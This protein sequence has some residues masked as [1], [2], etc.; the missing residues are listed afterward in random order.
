MARLKPKRGGSQGSGFEHQSR[1]RSTKRA[2]RSN[3]FKRGEGTVD[4]DTVA[5][6]CSIENCLSDVNKVISSKSSN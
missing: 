2:T 5:S 6:N 4:W 1:G 3:Y